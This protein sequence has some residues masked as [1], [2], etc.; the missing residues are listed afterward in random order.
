MTVTHL[1]H[2][3]L[4][5]PDPEAGIQFY[6]DFG[7]EGGATGNKAVMR[8]AGRDQDQVILVEGPR[9]KLHH[10]CFGTTEEGLASIKARV[11]GSN[12]ASLID[13]PTETPSEGIWIRDW[14]DMTYNVRV[15]EAAP[16]LGGPNGHVDVEWK[17]N[18]PGHYGRMG[19]RGAPDRNQVVKPRRLG[20]VLH[21]TTDLT[22]RQEFY[23]NV[24]GMRMSDRSA[25]IIAFM[26]C[27]GGSDHHVIGLIQHEKTGFHHASFEVAN[28][29]EVGL[30][31]SKMLEKGYKDGWGFGRHVIGS[32]FFHYIRDPWNGL[33][34]YFS[35]IDYIP[36]DYDWQAKDWDPEDSLYLWGPGVPE[37]F[38][39]NFEADQ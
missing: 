34:E 8:C 25:D 2:F 35:D 32:N 31:G 33:A 19:G 17:V 7:L 1:S 9:R 37:D 36:K 16:S 13:P 30:G 39:H 28:P 18:Q 4:Q 20:H 29:D 38:G 24:L 10:I 14:E 5:V 26:H 15:S 3:A 12:G 22:R 21:F 23:E 6:R 27:A 11:E